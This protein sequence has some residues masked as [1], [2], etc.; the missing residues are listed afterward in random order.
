MKYQGRIKKYNINP[1]LQTI[2]S[3]TTINSV[4]GVSPTDYG[5]A[6]SR[7]VPKDIQGQ[8]ARSLLEVK[9]SESL[10]P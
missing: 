4:E 8:L 9:S 10:D 6:S 5:G 7:L 1:V 3:P 2:V